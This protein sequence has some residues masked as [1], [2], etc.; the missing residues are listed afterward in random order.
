MHGKVKNCSLVICLFVFLFVVLGGGL[1]LNPGGALLAAATGTP[2]VVYAFHRR[3]HRASP[4]EE[5]RADSTNNE[6]A[7]VN[8]KTDKSD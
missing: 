5:V 1:H 2:L 3:F 8:S 6:V 4:P 7:Y